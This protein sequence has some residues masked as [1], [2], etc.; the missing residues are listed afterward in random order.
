MAVPSAS[1]LLGALPI[2]RTRLIGRESERSAARV[3]LLD[4]AVPLLTLTGPG[5][6]GKTRLALAIAGDVAAHFA[7]AVM[8]VDLAPLADPALVPA[9][10]AA[11]LGLRPASETPIGD[12]LI[13]ALHPR[14]TLLLL[15]NCEHLVD[16]TADLVAS[17]LAR[18]P[19]L[20]VLATSR[21]PLHLHAEQLLL[22]DPLPLPDDG[23]SLSA[24]AQNEAVQL[25][26]ERTRA[27]RPAFALTETNGATVAALCRRLDGLPLAIEL[28]AARGAVLS[29]EAML[30]QMS[31]RLQLLTHGARDL[32]ARQRTI[33]AAIAWSY[34]L[35]DPGAQAL[36]RRLA[37]FAGGFT[38]EAAAAV[39]GATGNARRHTVTTLEA[40]VEQG[41]VRR[42][43]GEPE[44]RFTMLETIRAYALDQPDATGER[45]P[46]QDAHAAYFIAFA[47]RSDRQR[48]EG[49]ERVNRLLQRIEVEQ[50]NIHAALTRLAA[51]GDAD[52]ALRLA[53][54]IAIA[55]HFHMNLREGRQWLEWA[56]AHA[57]ETATVA[58]GRA[59]TGLAV[60][61][62]VQG[63]YE[64]SRQRAEAS[65]AIAEYLNDKEVA[66]YAHHILGHPA[67]SQGHLERARFHL[68]K[69]L[70]FWRD[71]GQR[72]FE[73]FALFLLGRVDKGVGDDE[74]SARHVSE[75]LAIF[76]E[77]G[78]PTGA[79]TSLIFLGYLARDRQ[80]DR[81]AAS[82]FLEAL[83]HCEGVGDR[84]ALLQ[85]F[86]GLAD[87]TIRHAQADVAGV[88]IGVLDTLTQETG[89][90]QF[91]GIGSDYDRA[92]PAV[93]A[94]LGAA[95]FAELREAGR[96][97]RREQAI[98]LARTAMVL[99]TAT[100][101]EDAP[102]AA[103]ST[104]MPTAHEPEALR[105]AIE[106]HAAP[107]ARIIELLPV[108]A[109]TIGLTFREQEVLALLCQRLT[110]A[111]I[112][113]R[114]FLSRRTVNHHVANV[115]GKLG[116]ANRREAAALAARRGLI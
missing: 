15:D 46:A 36:F 102:W 100:G 89:L 3:Y 51:A 59:L 67:L 107:M 103:S 108:P 21:A 32:P 49:V 96:R 52:G 98:E 1:P 68:K 104:G 45:E 101:E 106:G 75:A 4:E 13:H 66:A 62:W 86:D 65:L 57:P 17:L 12:V 77:I 82:A 53:S 24:V 48:N 16:A 115:L 28:A 70:G 33:A 18:C 37:V 91:P 87:L 26:S 39:A 55:W 111:E 71:H 72:A 109:E 44:P 56:L 7:D 42:L 8:W 105:S 30:A 22:V 63:H 50:A 29:P 83:E 110:D 85:A 113:D 25:F 95:R 23:A 112:A 84:F 10:V 6:V 74:S 61:L 20:Q 40:L 76:R 34:D 14:Q 92:T 43:D 58:R 94:V 11:A 81:G 64:Q 27:V 69:G 35:L 116:V 97:L 54:A 79:A 38:L 19:A 90:T 78:H 114:L 47:E 88:L 9:A 80:D 93:L 73:A 31:D 41:L 99:V 5:G 60:I 2:S